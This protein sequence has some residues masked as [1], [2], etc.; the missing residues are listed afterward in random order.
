MNL[1]NQVKSFTVGQ[2]FPTTPCMHEC[3]IVLNDGREKTLK[4]WAYKIRVIL[5]KLPDSMITSKFDLAHFLQYPKT[6]QATVADEVVAQIFPKI[7]K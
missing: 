1:I 7:K 3:T 4:L 6:G 5:S 2:C